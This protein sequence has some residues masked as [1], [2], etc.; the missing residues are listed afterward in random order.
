MAGNTRSITEDLHLRHVSPVDHEAVNSAGCER[1]PSFLRIRLTPDTTP[2]HFA[3]YLLASLLTISF[4]VFINSTQPFVLHIILKVLP[5]EQ[6]NIN[7]SLLFYDQLLS[8]A[9]MGLWGALSDLAG[10]RVVFVLGFLLMGIA[11]LC[12]TLARTVFPEL[13]LVRLFF[14]V[15]AAAS[16]SMVTAV[17]ADY[18]GEKDKGKVSATVGLTSGFGAMLGAFVLLGLPTYVY[19]LAHQDEVLALQFSY[20]IVG[21]TSIVVAIILAFTLKPRSIDMLSIDFWQTHVPIFFSYF[22]NANPRQSNNE[23]IVVSPDEPQCE[24]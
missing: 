9:L 5:E 1:L 6:G 11:L 14:A 21:G 20:F 19:E 13:L 15:G 23:F 4:F 18:V 22:K 12:F 16:S 10:R 17:L 7:G 3:F 2:L 8:I 24:L